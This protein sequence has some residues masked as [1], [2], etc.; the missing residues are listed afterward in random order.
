MSKI[1]AM[2]THTGLIVLGMRMEISSFLYGIATMEV[3][4]GSAHFQLIPQ[5]V[6]QQDG[7]DAFQ[8]IRRTG[9]TWAGH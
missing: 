9:V 1:T 2:G 6:A 8:L 3:T 7:S 5:R 4:C